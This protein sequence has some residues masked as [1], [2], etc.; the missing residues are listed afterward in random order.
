[1]TLLACKLTWS[2]VISGPSAPDY[3]QS[4]LFTQASTAH[5]LAC[6]FHCVQVVNPLQ[7]VHSAQP[8]FLATLQYV[9]LQLKVSYASCNTPRHKL[10]MSRTIHCTYH[11][12]YIFR[13]LRKLAM[14]KDAGKAI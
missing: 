11:R 14:R 4:R 7:L 13:N 10:V 5:V 2:D 9:Q 3:V 8:C 12:G 6:A 1:M